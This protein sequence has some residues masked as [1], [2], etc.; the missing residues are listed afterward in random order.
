MGGKL[1]SNRIS[2]TLPRT[3]VTAPRFTGPAVALMARRCIGGVANPVM[4]HAGLGG[5]RRRGLLP[6]RLGDQF[7]LRFR[8]ILPVKPVNASA[9][10]EFIVGA[11]GNDFIRHRVRVDAVRNGDGRN[12]IR[13][14]M[15]N[16]LTERM[17]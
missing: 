3:D 1:S 15:L 14:S 6:G 2:T 10:Y 9:G 4:D 11:L 7:F 17:L 16:G 8:P 13:A 5:C 12:P